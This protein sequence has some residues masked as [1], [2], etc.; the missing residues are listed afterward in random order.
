MSRVHRQQVPA[1][2]PQPFEV[3]DGTAPGRL[4]CVVP[5]AK[6]PEQLAPGTRS[7]AEKTQFVLRFAEMH[8][9]RAAAGHRGDRAEERWRDGVRR[10]RH[11]RRAEPRDLRQRIQLRNGVRDGALRLR[12]AESQQLAEYGSAEIAVEKPAARSS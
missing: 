2:E 12:A 5:D 10:V 6:P 1:D 9:D 8:A 11:D 3:L 7:I 4:P